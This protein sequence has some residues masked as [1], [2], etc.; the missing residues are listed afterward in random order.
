[1]YVNFE[2]IIFYK[3]I[4]IPRK[5]CSVENFFYFNIINREIYKEMSEINDLYF[6]IEI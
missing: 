2:P 3:K 1:M 6:L 5:R 4:F